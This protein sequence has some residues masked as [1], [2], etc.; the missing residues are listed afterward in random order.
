MQPRAKDIHQLTNLGA[1]HTLLRIFDA[2]GD[3][4][5]PEGWSIC[6]KSVIFKLMSSIEDPL[7]S[8]SGSEVD[9]KRRSEWHDTAVVVLNGISG[10]LA[11]YLDVLTVHPTFNSYWQQL[12]GHFASLLDFQVLEINTATFKALAQILSQ[13]QNGAKQNFNKTTIDLAWDLW[14]RG[15]P[16]AKQ[17]EGEKREARRE[18]ETRP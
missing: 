15:I 18:R 7:R 9:D 8:V 6:I 5:S 13:S 12:L 3:R 14:A 16:V 4:L 11:N 17:R 10:L 1:T 2:Y